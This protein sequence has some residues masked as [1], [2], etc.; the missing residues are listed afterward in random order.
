LHGSRGSKIHA[1]GKIKYSR[2]HLPMNY[3]ELEMVSLPLG[4]S[5]E[6][7]IS[8]QRECTTSNENNVQSALARGG[9]RRCPS[10]KRRNKTSRE[11]ACCLFPIIVVSGTSTSLASRHYFRQTGC[12][13]ELQSHLRRMP[14]H[15]SAMVCESLGS[16]WIHSLSRE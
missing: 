12:G 14:S 11:S 16:L 2:A 8:P 4:K 13:Q 5:T 15:L 3:S 9:F 10:T 1:Y 6:G 7:N